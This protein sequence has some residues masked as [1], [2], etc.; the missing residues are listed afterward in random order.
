MAR[1]V[2]IDIGRAA[3]K[4]AVVRSAYR[5]TTLEALVAVDFREGVVAED[6]IREAIGT[7]LG[8]A[9]PNDGI[10]VALDGSRATVRTFAVAATAQKQLAEVLPFELEAQLP[11]EMSETVFDF[12]VL[13]SRPP[14]KAEGAAMLEVLVA[15][16]R[17][18]DVRARI[19]LVKGALGVEPERVG[20]GA[21]PLAN[22][23]PFLPQLV[24]EGT[25]VVVDLG[26]DR[27]EF[28]VLRRGEPVFART[29]S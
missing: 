23:V 17:T 24:E 19:D 10:A 22:L 26:S 12:R 28:I 16:A 3:V 20:V 8:G 5:K 14:D 7:A 6:A 13:G 25:V 2:G 21:L 27:S 18:E 9:P 29:L 4:A 1:W 15:A 11:I